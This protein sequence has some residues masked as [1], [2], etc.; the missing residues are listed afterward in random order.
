MFNLE[1]AEKFILFMFSLAKKKGF[2]VGYT[3]FLKGN[4]VIFQIVPS[5]RCFIVNKDLIWEVL[6]RKYNLSAKESNALIKSY[7]ERNFSKYEAYSIIPWHF[8]TFHYSST[9]ERYIL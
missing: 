6:K 7:V 4:K 3:S 5:S 9:S 1:R 2:G 8:P